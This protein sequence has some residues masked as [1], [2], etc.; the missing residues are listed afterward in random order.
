VKIDDLVESKEIRSATTFLF[1]LKEKGK[2]FAWKY[3]GSF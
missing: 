2:I 1:G 3:P